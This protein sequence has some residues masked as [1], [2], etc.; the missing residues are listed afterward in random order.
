MFP[1]RFLHFF[2]VCIFFSTLHFG[3]YTVAAASQS[4]GCRNSTM[5]RLGADRLEFTGM[6]PSS[7]A[8]APPGFRFSYV[9]TEPNKASRFCCQEKFNFDV[10]VNNKK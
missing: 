10:I 7:N 3:K 5:M 1:S 4:M 8:L 2:L 9:T 6:P